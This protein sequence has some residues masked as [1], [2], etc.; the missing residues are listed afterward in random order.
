[1]TDIEPTS[2]GLLPNR[3][4]DARSLEEESFRE[5]LEAL[6]FEARFNPERKELSVRVLLHPDLLVPT[7]ELGTS[8]PPSEPPVGANPL[9]QVRGPERHPLRQCPLSSPS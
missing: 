9:V 6:S 8:P 1:M 2:F 5:L 7:D 3:E 4:V